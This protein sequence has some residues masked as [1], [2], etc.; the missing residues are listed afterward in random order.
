MPVA[1]APH[2]GPRLFIGLGV[3]VVCAAVVFLAT[4]VLDNG[5]ASRASEEVARE[6]ADRVGEIHDAGPDHDRAGEALPLEQVGP[7]HYL[8]T[9]FIPSLGLELPVAVICDD[10]HL[11]VSPCRYDGSY[12]TDD[13]M[14]MG[15]GYA[16][17]FGS[18]GSVG[19]RDEVR[20]LAVDGGLHRYIVSN[21]ETDDLED[22]NAILDDWDLTLFTFNA[23]GTCCVVRCVRA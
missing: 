19:I 5:R 11:R 20:F 13:L 2:R 17:H 9:L 1:S 10:E 23:D 22:I 6:L 3:A 18:L 21:V 15:E 8:G 7:Y 4:L 14:I 16:G 12:L